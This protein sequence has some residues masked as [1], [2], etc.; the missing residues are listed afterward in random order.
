MAPTMVTPDNAFMPDMS[1][2][3]NRLGTFLMMKYP[4]TVHT[5]NTIINMIGEIISSVY[6]PIA[7]RAP[8]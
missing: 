3:C 1:G 6:K 2:V 8:A 5:T 4:T 7:S